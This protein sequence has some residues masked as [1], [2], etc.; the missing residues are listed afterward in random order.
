MSR[1]TEM[2]E[3]VDEAGEAGPAGTFDFDL[4]PPRNFMTVASRGA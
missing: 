1:P 2:N 3:D 4:E